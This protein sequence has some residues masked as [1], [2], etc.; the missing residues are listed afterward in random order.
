LPI[1]LNRTTPTY[2][3][4]LRLDFDTNKNETI[5]VKA[6]ELRLLCK[7]AKK[8]GPKDESGE[9]LLEYTVKKPGLYRLQKVVD[10][11]KLEVQHR[12]SDTL[13]VICPKATISPSTPDRCV[14]D[15]SNL[16]VEVQGTPPMKVVYSRSINKQDDSIHFQSI[17]PEG[18]V[19]PLGSPTAN[20]L[21]SQMKEDVSWGGVHSA[22]IRINESMTRSGKWLYSIDE[23]HDG[24]GN[25]ANFSVH[26]ED[27][28]R[29]NLKGKYLDL[30]LI[31]H[32]LP[33]ASLEGCDT[34][35]SLKVPI[36]K[37]SELPVI[38]GPPG[39]TFDDATHTITWRF[40]PID[41]LTVSGEHGEEEIIEEF[42]SRHPRDR[43][44][45]HRAG[46]YTLKSVKNRFCDGEIKAPA[47]CLLTNPP[48]PGLAIASENIYD[49]CAGNS[50]GLV[51]DLDLIGTPPFDVQY[52]VI[53]NGQR[54]EKKWV[55]I[56]GLRHQLEL[57]PRDAGHFM[58]RFLSIDDEVYTNRLLEGPGFTLEQD[59][60]PPASAILVKPSNTLFACI[61]Q[62]ILVDVLI[63][64]QRPFVLEYE[65]IY[66]GKRKKHKVTDIEG[67]K[68]TISTE[69][70]L[71][72]GEYDLA[73]ASVQD[74]A[75]CKIFLND[76][77]K[78]AVNRQRPKASFGLRDG[79][80]K[81]LSLEGMRVDLPLRLDGEAPWD[82]TYRN[83]NDSTAQIF[84][85]R[86]QK[87]NDFLQIENRGIYQLLNVSDLHCPGTV[88][89]STAT[90]EVDWI[91]RP[92]IRL[93]DNA[94][95][96]LDG[97]RYL[98]RDVCEGDT[99]SVGIVLTG[100]FP[101]Q[102]TIHALLTL[103]DRLTPISLKVSATL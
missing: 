47:S 64:G 74:R 7:E 18:L 77:I 3:E 26:G 86:I 98:K 60:K 76:E 92:D 75:G 41:K 72:G 91:Q 32:E 1:Q 33:V 23:V 88:D 97:D 17:Q 50:I 59:V 21:F 89:I 93:S 11:S 6:K 40:S 84:Q 20:A 70:L 42:V 15:L 66:E 69:P 68:L 79:K 67:E 83:I 53:H 94:G 102:Y 10:D 81:A 73:L 54:K 25:V 52:E 9:L 35:N 63:Q 34:R 12:M 30:A 49:K 43:P 28:E 96:T 62:P 13:V 55:H 61:G 29:I 85:T 37:S 90:F 82:I 48:E 27:G 44:R 71:N 95:M 19:S 5:E 2:I 57:K 31:V 56:K 80:R 8:K 100:D 38:F 14:G 39:R 22:G 65:L 101:I 99:D 78:I 45:I 87:A 46:L 4:L 16:T 103:I 51:V 58:Y 24:V 36:G